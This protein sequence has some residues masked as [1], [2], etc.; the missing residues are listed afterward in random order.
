MISRFTLKFIKKIN[1]FLENFNYE[2]D[3]GVLVLLRTIKKKS[4]LNTKYY[5]TIFTNYP[6]GVT[7]KIDKNGK[8]FL[9]KTIDEQQYFLE[10]HI[11]VIEMKKIKIHFHTKSL[12]N[13]ALVKLKTHL[14]RNIKQNIKL[15]LDKNMILYK[16]LVP[17]DISINDV[18]WK[19][20]LYVDYYIND[21]K[22]FKKQKYFPQIDITYNRVKSVRWSKKD[23]NNNKISNEFIR[24]LY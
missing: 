17:N 16:Y 15:Y 4:E 1:K 8:I 20:K 2:L 7:H 12:R 14:D 23:L 11:R 3:P 9:K 5:N 22:I 21:N 24:N 18:R 10:G 13:L 19:H 6:L